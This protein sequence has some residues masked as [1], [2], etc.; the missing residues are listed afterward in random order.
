MRVGVL[1][2]LPLLGLALAASSGDTSFRTAD[3]SDR[4]AR[5]NRARFLPTAENP[6]P[7]TF[8]A[9]GTQPSNPAGGGGA[10]TSGV[11]GASTGGPS[12]L[13][14]KSGQWS[15][16]GRR[17]AELLRSS[18]G[19]A[20]A[21]TRRPGRFNEG[22]VGWN[23]P[24]PVAEAELASR[25][26]LVEDPPQTMPK[27]PDSPTRMA[28]ED[29]ASRLH[30]ISTRPAKSSRKVDFVDSQASS[31]RSHASSIVTPSDVSGPFISSQKTSAA[32]SKDTSPRLGSF[33][34]LK[35]IK[36]RLVDSDSSRGTST[37]ASTPPGSARAQAPP[38]VPFRPW[39]AKA[40]LRK[41]KIKQLNGMQDRWPKQWSHWNRARAELDKLD[42]FHQWDDA[43]AWSSRNRVDNTRA[44]RVPTVNGGVTGSNIPTGPEFL[45]NPNDPAPLLE[46]EFTPQHR[47]I[48]AF[49][50]LAANVPPAL[51]SHSTA[52]FDAH[53]QGEYG[54]IGRGFRKVLHPVQYVGQMLGNK[55]STI[56]FENS[57]AEKLHANLAHTPPEALARLQRKG[58]KTVQ[59]MLGTEYATYDDFW[60]PH[61]HT[62]PAFKIT[63]PLD[64]PLDHFDVFKPF[65]EAVALR[66]P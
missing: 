52:V 8:R 17:D 47:S 22:K 39:D 24:P 60:Y 2:V 11:D 29:V 48:K 42:Y 32:A 27:R 54:K 3:S 26:S 23:P 19:S 14:P 46:E 43:M 45:H 9:G 21:T 12:D 66:R 1:L 41:I 10:S 4:D 15:D 5:I 64:V 65:S 62:K 20:R 40:A 55:E 51:T 28:L 35:S 50:E 59:Q 57:L 6:Q 7:F 37:V 44:A 61:F 36:T 31:M 25:P 34:W 18:S 16:S 30:R 53:E 13:G 58:K 49:R 63:N 33:R 56:A 38:A